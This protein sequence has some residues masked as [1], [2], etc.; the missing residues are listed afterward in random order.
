MTVT[1]LK[2][3]ASVAGW[4]G[5]GVAE[6]IIAD[7]GLMA[8]ASLATETAHFLVAHFPVALKVT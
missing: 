8:K 6:Q 4:I 2:H 5:S 3:I 1:A 7:S